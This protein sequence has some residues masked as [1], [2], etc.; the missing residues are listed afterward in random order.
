MNRLIC[1][2][3][4]W[5]NL[6]IWN[7]LKHKKLKNYLLLKKILNTV[8]IFYFADNKKSILQKILINLFKVDIGI[9][10]Y[11]AGLKFH[12]FLKEMHKCEPWKKMSTC[13][14]HTDMT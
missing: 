1:F 10:F 9:S 8:D 13:N 2:N 4:N 7:Y 3:T 14:V 5:N 6:F 11:S 12:R